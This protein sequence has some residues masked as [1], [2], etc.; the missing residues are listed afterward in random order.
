MRPFGCLCYPRKIDPITKMSDHESMRCIML[1]NSWDQPG[2]TCYE[3]QSKRKIVT[4]DLK[5]VIDVFP[6][7]RVNA[8]GY[9]TVVPSFAREH[10]G[11]S[12]R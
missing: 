5:C 7:L 9:E 12:A 1:G 4:S 2:Y 6:G 10:A 3:P 8:D 11:V